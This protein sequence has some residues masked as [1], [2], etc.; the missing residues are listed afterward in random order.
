MSAALQDL[1]NKTDQREQLF[2]LSS[3]PSVKLRDVFDTFISTYFQSIPRICLQYTKCFCAAKKRGETKLPTK[4]YVAGMFLPLIIILLFLQGYM[5]A[6]ICVIEG[7]ILALVGYKQHSLLQ[8]LKVDKTCC[9]IVPIIIFNGAQNDNREKEIKHNIVPSYP[10]K[11][12]RT[13]ICIVLYGIRSMVW[14]KEACC[15]FSSEGYLP[16]QFCSS[17]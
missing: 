1:P 8:Q 5:L 15:G 13:E 12:G 2:P 11:Q 17:S 16:I 9:W 4:Q 7:E 3:N 6:P 10:V 14:T